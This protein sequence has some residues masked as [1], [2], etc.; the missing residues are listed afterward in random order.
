VTLP[1]SDKAYC[2]LLKVSDEAPTRRSPTR[3]PDAADVTA[4]A[5]VADLAAS[6]KSATVATVTFTAVDEDGAAGGSKPAAAYEL[7]LP[8]DRE[9]SGMYA[10][11]FVCRRHR[12]RAALGPKAPGAAESFDVTLP[13]SDAVLLL[14]PQDFGRGRQLVVVERGHRDD[15]GCDRACSVTDLAASAASGTAATVTFTAV[16]EDGIAAGSKAGCGV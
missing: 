10:C 2:L 7:R 4:P 12:S 5:A 16:D 15:A 6:A 9:R 8:A 13:A 11:D 14:W 3:R 1:A